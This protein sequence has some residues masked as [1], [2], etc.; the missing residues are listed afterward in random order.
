M[1]KAKLLESDSSTGTATART[2]NEVQKHANL[3]CI[4]NILADSVRKYGSPNAPDSS[5]R[6]LNCRFI[7]GKSPWDTAFVVGLHLVASR[8][9]FRPISRAI[10]SFLRRG[11]GC[12]YVPSMYVFCR[13]ILCCWAVSSLTTAGLL[14]P[15]ICKKAWNFVGLTCMHIGEDG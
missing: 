6:L 13:I 2:K 9:A 14:Y 5:K 8:C 7:T 12:M 4:A 1:I 3:R 10:P 11:R 15:C